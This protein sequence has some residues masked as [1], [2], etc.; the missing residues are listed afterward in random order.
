MGNAKNPV[1]RPI[2]S[3][4]P[5][6]KLRRSVYNSESEAKLPGRPPSSDKR[7]DVRK[8]ELRKEKKALNENVN[9]DMMDP[10]TQARYL[11][12][13]GLT[14]PHK[15]FVGPCKARFLT[16]DALKKM[17]Q[18]HDNSRAAVLS[19]GLSPA[20]KQELKKTLSTGLDA[21]DASNFIGVTRRSIRRLLSAQEAAYMAG[22]GPVM[23]SEET[24]TSVD[25]VFVQNI[26]TK[27]YTNFFVQHSGVLSGARRYTRT[28]AI[29]K[30]TLMARLFGEFPAMLR[31]VLVEHPDFL[32]KL[33]PS[34]R[35]HQSV[36]EALHV[37]EENGFLLADEVCVRT[38]MAELLY[39]KKLDVK[40]EKSCIIQAG[41]AK[42]TDPV[43]LLDQDDIS[44]Q[45]K[46]KPVGDDTFW[47]ILKAA[48]LKYTTNLKPTYCKLCEEGP[49]LLTELEKNA[50]IAD[51]LRQRKE[52]LEMELI[53]GCG[54][55]IATKDLEYN[56]SATAK[57][58]KGLQDNIK[59]RRELS[60]A[61]CKYEQ[62]LKQ[63]IHC[64]AEV[65]K[66]EHSLQQG[67]CL[68][69]RDFVSQYCCDGSKMCN[70]QLVV[71]FKD[72]MDVQRQVQISNFSHCESNDAFFVQDVMDL[73]MK[74]KNNG[75]SGVFDKYRKITIT[76]DHGVHFSDVQTVYNES[77]MFEKYGKEIHI[78]S[79]CSYHCY[80]R[81]DA[82]GVHSKK[83]AQR[84][85]KNGNPLKIAKDY[86][87]AVLDDM[88]PDT[89]AY[90]FEEINRS[91]DVFG[92]ELLE[93]TGIATLRDMCEIAFDVTYEDGQTLRKPGIIKCRAVPF[94]GKFTVRTFKMHIE[95]LLKYL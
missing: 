46:I 79:L 20:Q 4:T 47:E 80:N 52:E 77:R 86:T 81:C 43:D 28:L 83:L 13:M 73:H 56:R 51:R 8:G 35:L 15:K 64:R 85:A 29:P 82:A 32:D 33:N 42:P 1:G 34:S 94:D 26:V 17:K 21:K 60:K 90:T 11:L 23:T 55:T 70:L 78:V 10:E 92:T 75:G 22:D 76:G 93:S 31:A 18:T 3:N 24:T 50:Q 36:T 30:H 12:T 91:Q 53:T 40:R 68:M 14:Y 58:E 89:I 62:H 9:V 65:K 39:R 74:G 95:Y 37:K 7:R 54:V 16:E 67:E 38:R 6:N 19:K 61:M 41:I 66:I 27:M 69:Y 59:R 44:K 72:K 2:S 25:S 87:K 57:C 5:A 71:V 48:K 49:C 45:F 84:E 88:R 63:F